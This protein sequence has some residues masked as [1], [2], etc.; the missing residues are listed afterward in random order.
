MKHILLLV[1]GLIGLQVSM[2]QKHEIYI[3]FHDGA[4]YDIY[5]KVNGKEVNVTH[6]KAWEEVKT[7]EISPD[8]KYFFFRHK[9]DK[10]GAYRLT[11]YNLETL[12]QMA[13]IV[14]GFGGDFEWNHLNQILHGW[15]CGTN[16]ANFRVYDLKLKEVFF[17]LSSGGFEMNPKKDILIQMGMLGREFWIYDLRTI[18]TWGEALG[19]ND[20]VAMIPK[21]DSIR[22]NIWSIY[23]TNDY[24]FEVYPPEE[25]GKRRPLIYRIEELDFKVLLPEDT[26]QFYKRT[27]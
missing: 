4:Y 14:P 8:G 26:K 21:L 10:G 22:Y 20:T 12:T 2:A 16:C 27:F 18:P 15:G 1:I 17:T 23:F 9:A 19:Y 25:Y 11:L 13:E 5:A 6:F 3:E 7:L 24:T